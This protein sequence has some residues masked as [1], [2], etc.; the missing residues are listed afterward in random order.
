[1]LKTTL[2]PAALAAL[3]AVAPAFTGVAG[4]AIAPGSAAAQDLEIG[5]RSVADLAE[6]LLNSV[7][8]ISTAQRLDR[9]RPSIAPDGDDDTPFREFFDEFFDQE[10]GAPDPRRTQSLGSGFVISADGVVVTNNHV[11]SD[12]DEVWVNFADGR[13]L[14]AEVVG[15]DEQTDIAVL[16]V[17]PDDPLK[18]LAFAKS[19]DLRV[20]DWVMAIGNPF[21]LGGTVT[22][23]I[24]SARNRNLQSGPYDDYIQTD[25]AINRGNSG[26]PLFDMRGN[27]IGINTAILS[28]TGGS[29]G[30]G[31]AIPSEI[32]TNVITQLLEFGETRRGWLGVRIQEV[33][34]DMA[35]SLGLA[36]PR[37]AL[38]AGVTE[39]GP[40]EEGG[41]NAGD[42]VIRFDG[43]EIEEMRELP[44]IVAETEIGKRV[45][46][47]VLRDG[48]EVEL[49]VDLG[50]LED[51][52]EA[53]EE[54]AETDEPAVAGEA[55]GEDT[56]TVLGMVLAPLTDER[57][58]TFEVADDVS[59][60]VVVE[61]LENSRAEE[62]RVSAG[63]VIL[64]VD[65]SPVTDP[66]EVADEVASLKEDG[67][68]T[69]LLTLSNADGQL[70]FT[71][72][73]LAD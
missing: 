14:R 19:E 38:I 24:I 41:L 27:V 58:E 13:E 44:R 71:T 17:D 18:P 39:D 25:A 31:F 2:G 21:G 47:V 64:E 8:N 55:E 66:Q 67:R 52:E 57:R 1:V 59:G 33:S 16:R 4:T 72:L 51:E 45:A 36:E 35:E 20:G 46:V 50:Q 69:A 42:V 40:A 32:A 10:E 3:F 29:V 61:V 26:G 43:R 48:E 60:V 9:N 62:K 30:I 12:A 54:A 15:R 73:R 65:Q 68:R 22:V 5:P 6:S 53:E 49:A 34:D 63:D 28:P 23:G 11:I 37:G 7:V 56:V 70:R